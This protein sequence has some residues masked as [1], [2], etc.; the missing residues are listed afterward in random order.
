[1]TRV[2]HGQNRVDVIF[3]KPNLAANAPLTLVA[4]LTGRLGLEAFPD[5]LKPVCTQAEFEADCTRALR[6]RRQLDRGSDDAG[7]ALGE[8]LASVPNPEPA[9]IH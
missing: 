7:P 9:G 1:V 3:D 8:L 4:T 2:S 5:V 6:Q